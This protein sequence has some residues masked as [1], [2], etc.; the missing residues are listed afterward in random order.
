MR[1]VEFGGSAAHRW[2]ESLRKSRHAHLRRRRCAQ[3][4]LA[5]AAVIALHGEGCDGSFRRS[6][7]SAPR[8]SIVTSNR[9]A[10]P[11]L[12]ALIATAS[13]SF[14]AD[15]HVPGDFA[16]VQAAH[17]AAIAGDRI[18]LAPGI[19]P[20]EDWQISKAVT[21]MS[22]SG[23]LST[24]VSGEA[25]GAA[26]RAF[27]ISTSPTDPPVHIE[28]LSFVST[29]ENLIS[30]SDVELRHCRFLRNGGVGAFGGALRIFSGA[31]ISA[32]QCSFELCVADGAGAVAAFSSSLEFRYCMFLQNAATW[33]GGPS[34]GGALHLVDSAAQFLGCS[35]VGNTASIGG[36]ICRWWGNPTVPVT[37]CSF[38]NN[39]SNW[40]CCVA[41]VGCD[42]TMPPGF[43]LDCNVNGIDDAVEVLLEPTRDPNQDGVPDICQCTADLVNDTVVNGAD[44]AIVLNFWGTDGSQFPGVD[45]DGDS[46]VNG[47]DL[48]AVL[49][50][51]GPCPE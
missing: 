3:G 13:A 31:V 8:S 5:V 38:L 25:K 9:L 6:A 46:I 51:W 34:E 48:A 37:D 19:Y 24:V 7:Q 42:S 40:N 30:A 29:S 32:S 35:F 17:D 16:T 33:T 14:A 47:S 21:I 23:P 49:N 12:S 39:S 50:A 44:M 41:C 11:C 15:L 26:A 22:L 10:L 27:S 20:A 1:R 36:A 43:G 4:A 28:G 18:I 45:I 2:F